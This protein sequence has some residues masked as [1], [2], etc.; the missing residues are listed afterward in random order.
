LEDRNSTSTQPLSGV[1]GLFGKENNG[2]PTIRQKG[3]AHTEQL[4]VG[5]PKSGMMNDCQ[6]YA[7]G[8]VQSALPYKSSFGMLLAYGSHLITIR[9]E[10]EY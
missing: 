6:N 10:L 2:F 5:T 8:V 3:S 1:S 4:I 9:E 7:H